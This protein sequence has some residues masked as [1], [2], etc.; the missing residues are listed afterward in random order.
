ML[1]YIPKGK[2]VKN[3]L[4]LIFM[5][6]NSAVLANFDGSFCTKSVEDIEGVVAYICKHP[7]QDHIS[8]H[9]VPHLLE[10][11]TDKDLQ[12][13]GVEL[14][15]PM[16]FVKRV[17]P[18][19]LD[20]FATGP[21]MKLPKCFQQIYYRLDEFNALPSDHPTIVRLTR[22]AKALHEAGVCNLDVVKQNF[23]DINIR[24][25]EDVLHQFLC[26]ANSESVF[27]RDNIGIGGRGPFGIHPMHN[28]PKGTWATVGRTPTKLEKDGLCYPSQ[29]VVR[30]Q[31]GDEIEDNT[32]YYDSK[33]ILDN[34]KCA[35][36]LYQNNKN[37]FKDWGTTKA[38]G[39]NRHCSGKTRND[40]Q[41]FKHLKEL[42]CCTKICR[43]K[44]K[45]PSNQ[46]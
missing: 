2:M 16:E 26:I 18:E 4:I 7:K 10:V 28:Q 43:D 37:G 17:T 29:A 32:A 9:R 1:A 25:P 3:S 24:I 45:K 20:A 21:N 40:L 23:N 42:G 19:Q 13:E 30:D 14:I 6:I 31:K 36:K 46:I 11:Q 27:G 35:V 12:A 44:F 15:E 41:F 34:A 5:L 8:M 22:L 33:V 38:W 39:S